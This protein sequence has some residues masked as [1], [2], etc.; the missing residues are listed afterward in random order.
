MT[1]PLQLFSKPIATMTLALGL[2]LGISSGISLGRSFPTTA[3]AKEPAKEVRPSEKTAKATVYEQNS[4]ILGRCELIVSKAGLRLNWK[5]KNIALVAHP[6]DWRMTMLNTAEHKYFIALP[7]Q[8]RACST[9]VVNL[10]R[11]IDTSVLKPR[12]T[13]KT[14]LHGRAVKKISMRGEPALK[15]GYR[16]WQKLLLYSADYWIEPTTDIPPPVV[17]HIQEMYVLPLAEGLP[18][19]LT[20]VN[21]KSKTTKELQLLTVK[22]QTVTGKDFAIPDKYTLVKTQEE[23]LDVGQ[24]DDIIQLIPSHE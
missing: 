4:K 10:Y 20:T 23:L 9:M 1:W 18:L 14:I 6:P 3:S 17:R 2:S 21:N 15:T 24:G 5:S 7:G 11:A 8:L 19:Q 12:K 22:T 16:N 13:E